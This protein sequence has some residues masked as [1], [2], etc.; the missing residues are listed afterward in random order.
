[1]KKNNF[2]YHENFSLNFL[3]FPKNLFFILIFIIYPLMS[4]SQEQSHNKEQ[5]QDIQFEEEY[6][7]IDPPPIDSEFMFISMHDWLSAICNLEKPEKAIE[8]YSIYM[9]ESVYRGDTANVLVIA[10]LNKDNERAVP[11]TKIDFYPFDI[12]FRLPNDYKNLDHQGLIDT[13]NKQL[14]DFINSEKFKKS[15]L[16][17]SKYITTNF[18]GVIWKHL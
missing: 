3:R 6:D 5:Y 13:L 4:K 17:H 1:M 12:Y 2:K 11:T 18:S 7:I 14:N 8:F 10:G 16:A 9:Y 15:F